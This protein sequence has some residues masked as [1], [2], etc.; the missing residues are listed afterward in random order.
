MDEIAEKLSEA[1]NFSSPS[2]A[3]TI[4]DGYL[5]N[6]TLA[7]PILKSYNI[8]ATIYLT[9]SL[10]GTNKALWVDDLQDML[11][12]TKEREIFFPDVLGDE[13]LDISS[14]LD[15]QNAS[16]KLFSIMQYLDHRKKIQALDSLKRILC[17]QDDNYYCADRK[18]LNWDE[19]TEMAEN[20]ICFGAHTATHPTLSMMD[21]SAAQQEI[22]VSIKKIEQ[23][24]GKK[25]SHFA[26]PNGKNEDFNGDLKHYCR[27]LG[28]ETVVSTE[29]G[30]VSSQSD[31]YFLKRI[32]PPPPIY[33]FACQLAIYM[34]FRK[35]D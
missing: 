18:M 7:Y 16:F 11:F 17:L 15:K 32:L 3:I 29:P 2:I 8:P 24:V 14:Q 19:V 35:L 22:V 28:L 9:T 25:V 31:L 23:E 6:Y 26:I 5:S 34:F 21:F 20:N 33:V 13:V 12:A 4:D 10:I 1:E 27:H 30:L